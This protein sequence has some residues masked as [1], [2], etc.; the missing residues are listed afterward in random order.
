MQ[1]DKEPVVGMHVQVYAA[2]EKAYMGT[3]VIESFS[4]IVPYIRVRMD[5]S[6]MIEMYT[7]NELTAFSHREPYAHFCSRGICIFCKRDLTTEEADRNCDVRKAAVDAYMLS[8]E[9]KDTDN[10]QG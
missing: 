9:D 10:G 1:V 8:R 5:Q 6:N 4:D 7:I 3:G 2:P